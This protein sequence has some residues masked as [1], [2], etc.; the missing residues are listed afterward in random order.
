MRMIKGKIMPGIAIDAI[1][2]PYSS[3]LPFTQV[4]TP[5]FQWNRF[6]GVNGQPLMIC[7]HFDYLS[8][9]RLASDRSHERLTKQIFASMKLNHNGQKP[10]YWY[11]C[12]SELKI[13]RSA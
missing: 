4:R 11:F 6:T 13:L 12:T 3:P 5:G 7:C 8:S 1:V 10:Y 2:L 9:G